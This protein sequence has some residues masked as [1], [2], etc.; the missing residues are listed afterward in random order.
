[1]IRQRLLESLL[2]RPVWVLGAILLI[3]LAAANGIRY[4]QVDVDVTRVL[5]DDLP[6]KAL[7]D[8][9]G[10]LFPSKEMIVIGIE[11]KDLFTPENLARLDRLTQRLEK[12]P[13]V[14]AVLSPTSARILRAVPGGI[15]TK[16]A[17]EFLPTTLKQARALHAL[18]YDQPAL[19]DTLLA[20]KGG[21][22]AI[23]VFVKAGVREAEAAREVM[24]L[25]ADPARN[26]GYTLHAS[27]RPLSVYWSK[28]VM[29]RDMGVMTT[30]ALALIMLFLFAAFRTARGVLL[31]LCVVTGAVVWTFGLMGYA[32]V[33]FTHSIEVLPILLL[34]IGV[35][36]SVHILKRY[37]QEVRTAP[38]ARMAVRA[39][40]ADLARPVILTS[41]TTMAG[42]AALD[43][44]GIVSIQA[45]GWLA[46][47]GVF[48]ALV[49]SLTFLPAALV[50]LPLP[51]RA[52]TVIPARIGAQLRGGR[53]ERGA[54]HYARLLIRRPAWI[55]AALG[56]PMI[57][58]AVA[59]VWVQVEFST[60]A[61]YRPD[62]PF[63]VASDTVNR[64]FASSTGLII[65]VDG[66]APDAI[67]EP[68]LLKKIE[69]LENWLRAQPHVGAVQSIAGHVKQTHRALHGGD[70]SA[71]RLPAEMEEEQGAIV[72]QVNGR[73]VERAVRFQAPG[74][75]LTSQYLALYEL[76]GRPDELANLV[77]PDYAMARVNVFIDSDRASVVGRLGDGVRRL[78]AE[79]GLRAELTGMAE[80]LR[81][82]NETVVYGQAWSIATSLLL[83]FAVTAL[84]F[85]SAVLAA[86]CTLPLFFSLLMNF[87][88]MGLTGIPLSVETMA[89]SAIAVGVG[90][91]YAIHV[92][93]R[94]QRERRSG[95]DYA[96][97]VIQ[98][99][100]GSGVVVLLNALVVAGGF[101]V[102]LLSAFK[103][104]EYLG[105]LIGLTMVSS[106]FA[107]LTLLPA[108]F[109]LLRPR[110]FAVAA[111]AK[112]DAERVHE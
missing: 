34:A 56:L 50:L 2:R 83:V 71:Y 33:P 74:R 75:D 92:V 35:A 28:K 58:G 98:T 42:F 30:A 94:F 105:L 108:I 61:N 68:A 3:T 48:A 57:L 11:E 86:F 95:L 27:G 19:V 29:A 54:E 97:A 47:F 15:E 9:I 63:R 24:E 53:L 72:E 7:Y 32:G 89:T 36:D 23:L 90:V 87:G 60:L 69:A 99:L 77:T 49:L 10:T 73:E 25:A 22:V 91:D 112:I 111:P 59:A 38:D 52:T 31:P 100:R 93:H 80:L 6:A 5:P 1:M 13:K 103:T 20:R 70:A 67:K 45:L 109:L 79:L 107:A 46:A 41:L 88:F 104:V 40:L 18:L 51:R 64:H 39:T 62:H 84:M 76:G 85:R 16:P 37:E 96:A 102:L 82:V 4:M 65:V 55:A 44:S 14:D 106:A 17:A 66:G 8:R 12:L 21:A 78:L 81:A 110:A 101:F 26:E 43:T